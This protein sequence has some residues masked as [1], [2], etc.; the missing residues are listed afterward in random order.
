MN[1]LGGVG[2]GGIP[3]NSYMF[4]PSADGVN[5]NKILCGINHKNIRH[6]S[7]FELIYI[8]DTTEKKIILY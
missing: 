6:P 1:Q 2:A 3:G 5:K 8:Q 4:A 7:Q